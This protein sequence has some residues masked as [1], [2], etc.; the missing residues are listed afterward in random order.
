M[1]GT[2]VVGVIAVGI[3]GRV[4]T[5]AK[6]R[7]PFLARLTGQGV[8]S[9][10]TSPPIVRLNTPVPV[11][12]AFVAVRLIVKKPGLLGTPEKFPVFVLKVTPWGIGLAVLGVKPG[13]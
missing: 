12:H 11:P 13:T 6:A 8:E 2:V 1:L 4:V 7:V 10:D 9:G 3:D 5:S